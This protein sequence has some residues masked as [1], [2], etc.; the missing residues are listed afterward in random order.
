MLKLT[1]MDQSRMD[2]I[3][4]KRWWG[5]PLL[6]LVLLGLLGGGSYLA[7]RRWEPERLARQARDFFDRG[8]PGNALLSLRRALQLDPN[9]QSASRTMAEIT[10]RLNSPA[11]LD[12]HR[13]LVELNPGSAPEALEWAGTAVRLGQAGV[14]EQALAAVPEGERQTARFHA[15]EGTVALYA[16]RAAD[17]ERA[18]LEAARL[19]PA[20][21]LHRYNLATLQ[22]Q[23]PEPAKR[24]SARK[25]LEDLARGGSMQT[26]ARRSL[27][28]FLLGE[29]DVSGALVSSDPLHASDAARFSDRIIH[30]TLLAQGRPEALTGELEA[31][32]KH[33]EKSADDAALLIQWMAANGRGEEALQWVGRLE[34]QWAVS[35]PVATACA[36]VLLAKQDWDAL[37]EACASG[38]WGAMDYLRL[39]YLAR[40]TKERGESGARAHWTA[41]SAA[42]ARERAHASQLASLA[43]EWGWTEERRETLW[44]AAASPAP[45]WALALLHQSYRAEGNTTGLLR[46]AMKILE[47]QPEN[48]AARNNVAMLSLL[49]GERIGTALEEAAALYQQAPETPSVAS[50]YAFALQAHGRTEEALAILQKLPAAVL[51]E[52][53]I[54]AYYGIILCAQGDREMARPY[55]EAAKHAPLLPEEKAL[56]AKAEEK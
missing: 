7:Y 56:L 44:A 23:S 21:E 10:S 35:G 40:A 53:A 27:I 19:E 1:L 31:V 28:T 13:R 24:A 50:T 5:K 32:R 16:G 54:A 12:W 18:F 14:A 6:F 33:A 9:S 38:G 52:P 11:A 37:R 55:L 36:T 48:T 15:L 39:A 30:L 4:Q 25:T 45:E 47:G 43:Q 8:E 3:P 20:Q 29:G 2:F 22:L 26:V 17:A 49:R 41:A 51:M 34:P 42:A 46:V